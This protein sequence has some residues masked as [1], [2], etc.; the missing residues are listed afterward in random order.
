MGQAHAVINLLILLWPVLLGLPLAIAIG[1]AA[2]NPVGSAK[3]ALGAYLLGFAL[4]LVAKI[5]VFRSGRL[6]TF[7]SHAMRRPY[8]AL[9]RTGYAFMAVGLLFAIGLLITRGAPPLLR[10]SPAPETSERKT[11]GE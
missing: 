8:R 11:L 5:S 6:V 3:L 4:F 10:P 2:V 1:N 9:Y 7:G